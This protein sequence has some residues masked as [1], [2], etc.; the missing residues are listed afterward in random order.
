MKVS[1]SLDKSYSEDVAIMVDV[2]RASTTMTVAMENF[3]QIIPVK[4]IGEAEKLADKY[5]A[6][7]AGER[8]G[9]I[10]EGFDVGNSPV[11]ISN[12]NGKVLVITTSNGTRILE[13]MKA[14][15]LIGSFVNANAVAKKAMDL[16]DNHI[17]IVMAGVEGRFAIEDFLG[18]GEII[19]NLID[20][21]LDEMAL[22]AYMSSRNH[23]LVHDAI[24]NSRSAYR[25][26]EL[27]LSNDVDFCMRRNIYDIVPVYQ[28]GRID[29]Q[30]IK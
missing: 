5:D 2:L 8:R 22:A 20:C 23:D 18:A 26:G 12:F 3:G 24:V 1:L 15:I 21:N 27:G 30:N 19:G 14:D 7:L 9:D 28:N 11:E 29:G 4:S 17:E 25:L 10:I 16:A 13:G 6:V